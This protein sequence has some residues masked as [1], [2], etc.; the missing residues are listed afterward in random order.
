MRGRKFKRV[1]TGY[2]YIYCKGF[3]RKVRENNYLEFT[4]FKTRGD[5]SK[6]YRVT[7]ERIC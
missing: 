1:I 7:I 5:K 3:N 6:K 2:M 4:I